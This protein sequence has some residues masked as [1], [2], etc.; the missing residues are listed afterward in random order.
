MNRQELFNESS[1][2][3]FTY[4]LQFFTEIVSQEGR[5]TLGWVNISIIALNVFINLCFMALV[6]IVK[7]YFKCKARLHRYN[8]KKNK[9]RRAELLAQQQADEKR[10][11][12]QILSMFPDAHSIFYGKDRAK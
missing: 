10:R 7:V 2:L 12:E 3:L 5:Y 11:K 1:V 9:Q 4:S 8:M 6:T